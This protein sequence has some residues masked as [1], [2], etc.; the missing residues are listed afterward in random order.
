MIHPRAKSWTS[1]CMFCDSQTANIQISDEI[2]EAFYLVKGLLD[3]RDSLRMIPI[4]RGRSTEMYQEPSG[5]LLT[6][7]LKILVNILT[8]WSLVCISDSLDKSRSKMEWTTP[9]AIIVVQMKSKSRSLMS[10]YK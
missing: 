6:L 8:E 5:V 1:A 9:V 4:N 3:K 10:L 7:L 2:G